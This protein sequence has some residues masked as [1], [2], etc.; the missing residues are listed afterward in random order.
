MKKERRETTIHSIIARKVGQCRDRSVVVVVI[1]VLVGGY[2]DR[3]SEATT[4]DQ[5]K[6]Y[7]ETEL[8]DHSRKKTWESH[9]TKNR[10]NAQYE[11]SKMSSRK[12]SRSNNSSSSGINHNN[13]GGG[14]NTTQKRP[15][16]MIAMVGDSDIS[17][18]PNELYPSLSSFSNNNSSNDDDDDDTASMILMRAQGG[19]VMSELVDQVQTILTECRENETNNHDPTNNSCSATTTTNERRNNDKNKKGN[20]DSSSSLVSGRAVLLLLVA[21]AGENNVGSGMS[22][23]RTMQDFFPL[24]QL[25]DRVSTNNHNNAIRIGMIFLGPKFEPW[26][27]D[28]H[29]SKMRKQYTKL[30]KAMKRA[31]QRYPDATRQASTGTDTSS[32]IEY[33]DCLTMFA[34][35]DTANLPGAISAGRAQPDPTYFDPD[36]LHLSPRG[37]G[38][39]RQIVNDHLQTMKEQ[40]LIN[41]GTKIDN[42]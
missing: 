3:R 33:V 16:I 15:R 39:W 34:R 40:L 22:V 27:K 14:E 9:Q 24:L 2:Q 20:D 6:R 35:A 25:L 37:Y 1:V 5:S 18:W 41:N 21:C 42:N 13:G 4:I 36:G 12:S 7:S 10:N 38:I 19:A 31:C 26:M 32:M 29:H 17:R 11:R 30:S 23:D 8:I 28:P